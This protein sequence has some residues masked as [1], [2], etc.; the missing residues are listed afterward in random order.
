MEALRPGVIETVACAPRST[1]RS[2]PVHPSPN[3]TA[4]YF[5]GSTGPRNAKMRGVAMAARRGKSDRASRTAM[6]SPGRPTVACREDRQRFWAAI[7]RG[8]SSKEAAGRPECRQRNELCR[9][10]ASLLDCVTRLHL[11]KLGEPVQSTGWGLPTPTASFLTE[12]LPGDCS[13]HRDASA[14]AVAHPPSLE[15]NT[16]VATGLDTALNRAADR[17]ARGDGQPRPAPLRRG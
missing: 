13:L 5:P 2:P 3:S 7:A 12:R 15:G 9:R 1:A 10:A 6:H 4:V 14:R 16:T 8:L 11:L 17:A